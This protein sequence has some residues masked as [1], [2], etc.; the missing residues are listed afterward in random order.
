M[1][2]LAFDCGTDDHL[3]DQNRRFHAFL[4]ARGIRHTYREHPGGHTWEYWDAHVQEALKQ[5]MDEY[6][7]MIK[8]MG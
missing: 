2:R 5:H 4:D 8:G 1:P 3:L 7:R 6:E